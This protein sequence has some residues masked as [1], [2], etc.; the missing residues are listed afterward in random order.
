MISEFAV[1]TLWK[2]QK[3]NIYENLKKRLIVML[4]QMLTQNMSI[5]YELQYE[6]G[7]VPND[8]KE[9]SHT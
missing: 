1:N 2:N 8:I 6:R 7:A 3:N 4:V 9:D 5:S